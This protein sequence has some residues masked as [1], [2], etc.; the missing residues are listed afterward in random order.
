VRELLSKAN[1]NW[2]IIE[3]LLVQKKVIQTE[4]NGKKFYVRKFS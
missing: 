2:S 1:A 4:Y 3:K